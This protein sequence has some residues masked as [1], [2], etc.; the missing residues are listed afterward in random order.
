VQFLGSFVGSISEGISLH[1]AIDV[2]E[3]LKM[4]KGYNH[5]SA[6]LEFKKMKQKDNEFMRRNGMSESNIDKMYLHDRKDF[7]SDRRYNERKSKHS[8]LF[9]TIA[10][11][12]SEDLVSSAITLEEFLDRIPIVPLSQALEMVSAQVRLMSFLKNMGYSDTE[13]ARIIGVHPSTV[14]R[15]LDNLYDLY[16]FFRRYEMDE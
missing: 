4:A 16:Q 10:T 15:N 11:Q 6:E 9:V 14:C 8:N 7:N 1:L 2:K 3:E 12:P 5:K 13:V